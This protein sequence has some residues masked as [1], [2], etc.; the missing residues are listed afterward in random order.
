MKIYYDYMNDLF[1]ILVYE[2]F[3]NSLPFWYS[4]FKYICKLIFLKLF[5]MINIPKNTKLNLKNVVIVHKSMI[6]FN[7][8]LNMN[9]YNIKIC[10]DNQFLSV[11]G[12]NKYTVFN[13]SIIQKCKPTSFFG[14]HELPIKLYEIE[15]E[16]IICYTKPG[17]LNGLC[18]HQIICEDCSIKLDKCPLCNSS[19]V[20]NPLNLKKILYI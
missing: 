2:F 8:L 13:Y 11:I 19:I 16:C 7:N 18:G 12:N 1:I 6:V 14:I 5:I 17:I 9:Y 10:I 20:K 3:N 15:K 4:L